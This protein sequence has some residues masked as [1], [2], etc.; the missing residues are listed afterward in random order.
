MQRCSATPPPVGGTRWVGAAHARRA[1]EDRIER[2]PSSVV[3]CAWTLSRGRGVRDRV[4]IRT[5]PFVY[6]PSESTSQRGA[7]GAR[8]ISAEWFDQRGAG[9]SS[10]TTLAER[11]GLSARARDAPLGCAGRDQTAKTSPRRSPAHPVPPGSR[12]ARAGGRA[13]WSDARRPPLTSSVAE[14]RQAC[15]VRAIS[16]EPS[17]T[18]SARAAA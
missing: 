10:A 17:C 2:R 5:P 4:R 6:E 7:G 11:P 14:P 8:S 15:A 9:S 3:A 18:R 1:G 16:T 12:C 13:C